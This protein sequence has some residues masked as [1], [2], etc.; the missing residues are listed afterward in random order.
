[1]SYE[2]HHLTTFEPKIMGQEPKVSHVVKP[3]SRRSKGMIT[4]GDFYR[5]I[6]RLLLDNEILL[7]NPPCL[8]NILETVGEV[9]IEIEI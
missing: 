7:L 6:I 3:K 5:G 9:V 4:K 2:A 1:M 8:K